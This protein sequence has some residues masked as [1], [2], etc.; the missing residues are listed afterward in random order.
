MPGRIAG[1]FVSQGG[2]PKLPVMQARVEA[3]GI[4]GDKV[5]HKKIHG[6][7]DRAL[8][9]FSADVMRVLQAEGHPV[10]PGMTGE[11]ILIEGLNWAVDVT[12]GTHWQLGDK[13]HIKITSYTE[14]CKQI[15]DAFS[16][17]HFRRILQEINPGFSRV[18]ARVLEPGDISVGDR[19][20]FSEV[21]QCK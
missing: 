19:I 1:L 12:P 11:N 17:R 15:A 13:L 18:Y 8:C 16:L 5:Q 2:V 6:G 20:K 7:P 3:A 14:P 9:L 21:Q 4:I 10:Q